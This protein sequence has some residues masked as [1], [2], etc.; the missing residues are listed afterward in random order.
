MTRFLGWLARI[1]YRRRWLVLACWAALLVLAAVGAS[2]L[3]HALKIGGF[4]LPGTEFN[5]ASS[6]LQ[7]DLEISSDKAALLVFHSTDMLVTDGA[8][9]GE[10]EGAL[11]RLGTD[12]RVTKLES[13]YTTGIPD[14]VSPDNHTTYAWVTL[15]GSE[16]ELEEATPHFREL[17]KSDVI[18]IALIGQAAVNYDVEKASAEDLVRVEKFTLPIVFVLLVLVFGSLVAAGVPLIMGA[19]S[20]A[21]SLAVLFL[22]T[23]VTDISIFALNTASMIGLGLAI[24][25]SLIVV[26]R[27]REELEHHGGDVE[28]A[29]TA[30]L[31]TSGRSITFSGVTLMLTMAVLSLF[32]IMV[33][34]SIALAIVVVAGVSITAGL[35]LL[36]ALLAAIGPRINR[37]DLRRHIPFLNRKRDG[38]WASWAHRVMRRPWVS[39][40]A[41]LAVLAILAAPVLFLERSGVTVEV[42]PK[43]AASRQ[44]F[45]LIQDG[46]GPGE[47]T[48]LFVVIET[49]D[50]GGIFNPDILGGVY[51]L[52]Q[53][54][55][56]D[57]RVASVQSLA[58]LIPNPSLAWMQSLSPATITSNPDRLRIAERLVNVEGT[59]TTTALIV[60]PSHDDT[61]EETISL[62]K[63]LRAD[64]TD[65]APG[66]NAAGRVLIGGSAAQHY[67]FDRVVYDQFPLLLILSLLVTF[68]IL[69]LF[70]HSLILPVKAILLNLAS[71]LAA[72]GVVVLVF[73]FGVGAGLIGLNSIDAVLSYTPVLL[74]S[75]VF[76]LST[77][78]E[79][80][81]LT[82]VREYH[83]A[84][85]S[86]EESV[87]KGLEHTAGIITA[88]G[89]I[90]IVVFGSFALTNVLVIKEI[91]FGLAAAVLIDTTIVRLV[92]VPASMKL[93]GERNW[94]MP[95]ALDRIVPEIDEGGS[96]A[97]PPIR[98]AAVTAD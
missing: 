83:L 30:T 42:L 56:A 10:V 22:I 98:P 39:L 50:E 73:Q 17:V 80:F 75:I 38:M 15:E 25:F 94:W 92:L 32:P 16:E 76:G 72:L 93:M 61:S 7:R 67:D 40:S 81:L 54:L 91:G 66:L 11:E 41:G 37:L 71:I 44:A 51:E 63:D 8:F 47:P 97:T 27:F 57:E 53:R 55:V 77:D 28:A 46:F 69:M 24:D 20:V 33:I 31:Q 5:T 2:R 82:R 43:D 52:H 9:H 29:L 12:P 87:A 59:G 14:M 95:K 26:S 18:D 4:S 68:V 86:N 49:A 34:R 35:F 21:S 62:M 89:L 6:V 58:S 13:F 60:Y 45:E 70:F 3:E 1:S 96:G 23:Q 64:A 90:M 65:W 79:V 84:G 36:P 85:D 19:V 88:A 74:F 78:Y 48:P